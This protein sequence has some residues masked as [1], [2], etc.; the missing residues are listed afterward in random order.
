MTITP[1]NDTEENKVNMIE[2]PVH[3]EKLGLLSCSHFTN[4][5]TRKGWHSKP[6]P[7]SEPAKF[8]SNI[9]KGRDNDGVLFTA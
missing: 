1:N 5:V 7:R 2:K 8:K 4:N 6:T 9:L 3:V